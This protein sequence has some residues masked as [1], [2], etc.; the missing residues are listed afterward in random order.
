[1]TPDRLRADEV[2]KCW[3]SVHLRAIGTAEVL[4]LQ[5]LWCLSQNSMVSA[6]EQ[7]A[8]GRLKCEG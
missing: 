7:R 3:K 2:L 1:M 5:M 8:A 4:N 6:D